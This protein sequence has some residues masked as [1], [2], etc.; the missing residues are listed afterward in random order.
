[1]G[2]L[3]RKFRST[4]GF[5]TL[6]PSYKITRRRERLSANTFDVDLFVRQLAACFTVSKA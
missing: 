3:N 2:G 6:V 1:M 5:A 4:E